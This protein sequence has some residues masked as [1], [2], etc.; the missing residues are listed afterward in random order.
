MADYVPTDTAIDVEE[1]DSEVST[2]AVFMRF[3][4]R[5]IWLIII[6]TV[7]GA[8]IGLGIAFRRDKTVYTQTKSII[9]IA[10][11]NEK[12]MSTNIPLTNKYIPTV[13]ESI[14]TPI[15]I[16]RANEIYKENFQGTEQYDKFG[17][18]GAGSIGVREGGGMILTISYN[19]Y[20]AKVAADKLDAFLEAS[21]KVF[22]EEVKLTSDDVD[23]VPIDNVPKTTTT[24][25]FAKF[26]LLS[27]LAGAVVGI[28]L[29][30]L[31]YMFDNTVT[32]RTDLERLTGATV[33]AYIDDVNQQ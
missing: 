8:G 21:Q 28:F 12:D 6:V 7:I 27:M 26:I 33:V 29:S 13:R 19:D 1:K 3:L 14:V 23:F 20:N 15:F 22:Q 32:S 5:F 30:F 25:E 4:H 18:I 2:F 16:S 17:G 11:I 10:K 31:I 9:F 24:T